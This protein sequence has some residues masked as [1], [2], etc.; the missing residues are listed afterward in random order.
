MDNNIDN[1]IQLG[2]RRYID[3]LHVYPNV[4]HPLISWNTCKELGILPDYYPYPITSSCKP[5]VAKL[6]HVN[7]VVNLVNETSYLSLDNIKEQYP[8]AFDGRMRSIEGE[9]SHISLTEDAAFKH[10]G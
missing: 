5:G 10:L 4:K 2:N 7:S 1:T 3:D 9:D 6:S 8:T